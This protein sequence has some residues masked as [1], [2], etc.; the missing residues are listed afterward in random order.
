V[1]TVVAG[2][3]HR[4]VVASGTPALAT[5]GSGDV[6]AGFIGAFLARGL[7]APVAAALGAHALGRAAEVATALNSAR[8]TRPADVLAAV[9][10]LWKRWAEEP[11]ARPPV[12]AE[13]DPPILA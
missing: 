6:L 7:A 1:P 2:D 5:G 12:L 10:A 13:L 3:G 4:F 9:P 8:A 11:R